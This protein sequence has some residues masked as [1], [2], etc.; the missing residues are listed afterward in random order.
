MKVVQCLESFALLLCTHFV[1]TLQRRA[2]GH[3]FCK[4][5]SDGKYRKN[6]VSILLMLLLQSIDASS[7]TFFLFFM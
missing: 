4:G 2:F 5:I 3:I 7:D 1:V 6:L